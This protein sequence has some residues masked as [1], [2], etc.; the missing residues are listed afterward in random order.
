MLEDKILLAE[1]QNATVGLKHLK[2]CFAYQSVSSTNDIALEL[3]AL[4]QK[5]GT[6][7]MAASQFNGRGRLL[8]SWHSGLGD[9]IMSI[10]LR[11]EYLPQSW[12]LLPFMPAVAI[13][14]GL[15][16]L[17]LKVK[18]KWPNDIVYLENE[19]IKKLGGILIENVFL[20]DSLSASIIGIGLNLE[21]RPELSL[22]VP[23]AG[24]IHSY[25]PLSRE[26]VLKSILFWFDQIIIGDK[27]NLL[28]EYE[29]NCATI[30][31][32]VY[33]KTPNGPIMARAKGIDKT[34]ALVVNDSIKDH[35][36]LA[37]DINFSLD[38]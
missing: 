33:L 10:I 11:A 34:G 25:A 38:Y 14:R 32:M 13:L 31:R 8:R 36:I 27:V 9:I 5:S 24:F 19:S 23:H 20:K 17:G 6:I 18:L 22:E 35:L 37:G 15:K 21:K 28:K 3:E 26:D 7:I 16:S 30:G 2:Q 29:E 1:L 4:G 12:S